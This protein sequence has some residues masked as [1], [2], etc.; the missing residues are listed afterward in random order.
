MS[1][2]SL[3]T[4]DAHLDSLYRNLPEVMVTGERPVVKVEAGKLVYDLPRLIGETPVDNVYEALKH[5]P[6][7]SEQGEGL[8]L[9]GQSVNVMLD[10][11]ATTMSAEQLYTLLKSMPAD[12]I[13]RAEV[14]YNAPARYRVRGAVI[15]IMLKHERKAK[16]IVQG[17][18]YG[19]YNQAYK[20]TF[21]ER[22]SL[23]YSG[24]RLSADLLYRFGHG[25]SYSTT[26]KEAR[27]TLQDGSVT[28]LETAESRHSDYTSHNARLGL[29]YTFGQGH[30]ASLVYNFMQDASDNR[31]TTDGFID[32]LTLSDGKKQLHNARL[33]YQTP[34]GLKAGA[35]V[36]HYYAPYDQDVQSSMNGETTIIRSTETQRINRWK[37]FVSG[38]HT[39]KGGWGINYGA[40][41]EMSIDHSSQRYRE[42]ADLP[43]MTS[44]RKE[45]TTNF[46]IGVGK[47]IGKQWSFD[48]SLEAE[49]YK[50]VAWNEWHLYPTLNVSFTPRAGH[51]LQL[52]LN[53]GNSYPEYWAVQNA[54][55]YLNNYS[56]IQGNP[57]LKPHQIIDAS[58]NYI[59]KGKYIFRAW[60]THMPDYGV[61]TFYQSPERL[62]EI[63][64]YVNFDYWQQSGIMASL[65]LKIKN[66]MSGRINALAIL[67]RQ[68]DSDFYD[69]PFNRHRLLPMLIANTT[70]TLSS[71][72]DLKLQVDG[73]IQGR[74]LQ[75]TYDLP[76][77]GNLDLSLRYAFAGGKG[78]VKLYANDL[79][80]TSQ[81]DPYTRYATQ[82]VTNDYSCYRTLGLSL[83]YKF[84]GYKEKKR[85][86]VDTSRFK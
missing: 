62:V 72:P 65:P 8:T 57:E 75:A 13:E 67:I 73:R 76:A 27:H 10:G 23:I 37:F 85:N 56:E 11:K 30:T 55:T 47:S 20:A 64:R 82:W 40:G 68:K 77:A 63:Y 66:V 19:Q 18:L 34:I 26:N 35:E 46:Y 70:W 6:G 7:V 86:A 48:L 42:E 59:L 41:Y 74:A 61:Q 84:G 45:E 50:T 32:A 17:E 36:T 58:L 1:A 60:L 52:A 69:L 5:L 14:M 44:R 9:S 24:R 31:L 49:H 25:D 22:A 3:L 15:N 54:T 12:R 2:D 81:I 38:E 33:D 28:N 71:K 51:I 39:L 16:P 43:G 4:T 83:T 21:S 79:L 80:E 53:T 78:I 29:D